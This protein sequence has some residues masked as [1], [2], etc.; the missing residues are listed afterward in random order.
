MTVIL[1]FANPTT[2]TGF[3]GADDLEGSS[4]T[5]VDKVRWVFDR[6][7]VA[8]HGL[9]TAMDVLDYISYFEKKQT[10]NGAAFP[11][12]QNAGD[13]AMLIFRSV[14]N[15]VPLINESRA[16][17][18]RGLQGPDFDGYKSIEGMTANLLILDT[19]LFDF[20]HVYFGK[21]LSPQARGFIPTFPAHNQL[22]QYG[23]GAPGP[24]G[25]LTA[26]IEQDPWPWYATEVN[27]SHATYPNE[28]GN[29]GAALWFNNN[30]PTF[31]SAFTSPEDYI[32]QL[33][34]RSGL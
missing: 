21:V 12:P 31:R 13:L 33:G 22:L 19:V 5:R 8:C 24:G 16:R 17:A 32:R 10:A 34:R 6:Y 2:R 9:S 27:Q 25:P 4:K 15:L 26:A 28:V 29:P 20:C 11:V 3:I 14:Q 1:A 30:Q 7:A 18:L 23:M